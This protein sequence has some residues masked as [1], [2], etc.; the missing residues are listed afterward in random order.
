LSGDTQV[1]DVDR[2]ASALR[3]STEAPYFFSFL[4]KFTL[5]HSKFF[6]FFAEE[7]RAV[8]ALNDF[9]SL[10]IAGGHLRSRVFGFL[11]LFGEFSQSASASVNWRWTSKKQSFLVSFPFGGFSQAHE[12]GDTQVVATLKRQRGN[13]SPVF[14]LI[15]A[16]AAQ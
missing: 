2:G 16:V 1:V 5:S 11:P 10:S 4:Q 7:A 9:G 3:L 12:R 6:L 14:F 8:D 13:T 15:F